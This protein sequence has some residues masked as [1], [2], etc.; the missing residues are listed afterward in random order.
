M[1]LID[2]IKIDNRRDRMIENSL[3]WTPAD[4]KLCERVHLHIVQWSGILLI[5]I[6]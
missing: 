4:W 5:Y 2:R 3:H 6:V 1:I